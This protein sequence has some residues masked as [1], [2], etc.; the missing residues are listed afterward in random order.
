MRVRY[1]IV[2]VAGQL[3]RVSPTNVEGLWEGR[4]RA[5]DLGCP[6]ANDLRLVTVVCDDRLLPRKCYVLRVPLT[7][8]RFT[9]ANYLTLR[10]FARP[11]CVTDR[12]LFDHHTEGWP[13]DF[14]RQLAVA[15]DVPVASLEVPV[16]IGGPLLV[17]AALDVTPRQALRYLE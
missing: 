2:D 1:F 8:G 10:I 3:R 13:G 5:D 16:G 15:L 7:G 4:V 9:E 6:P 17:A 14:F 12:E 11:D